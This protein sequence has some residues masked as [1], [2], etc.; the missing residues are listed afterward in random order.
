MEFLSFEALEAGQI[1]AEETLGSILKYMHSDC[2]V[3]Y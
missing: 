1:T 2:N 3:K